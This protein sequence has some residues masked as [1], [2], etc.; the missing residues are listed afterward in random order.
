MMLAAII[1]GIRTRFAKFDLARKASN[2]K[3]QSPKFFSSISSS[4]SG[5]V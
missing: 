1:V 5:S 3:F 4:S 2:N